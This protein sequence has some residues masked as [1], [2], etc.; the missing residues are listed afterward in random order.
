M[1]LHIKEDEDKSENILIRKIVNNS[2]L[3]KNVAMNLNEDEC[4][5]SS[6]K[7]NPNEA[8]SLEFWVLQ[9]MKSLASWPNYDVNEFP[10]YN[11]L[12]QLLIK[13]KIKNLLN[14]INL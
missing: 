2:A 9:A 12:Y 6:L 4:K 11:G 13:K 5:F 1:V 8:T 3:M 14:L 10:P 7:N